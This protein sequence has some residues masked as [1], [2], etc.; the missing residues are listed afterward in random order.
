MYT[1]IPGNLFLVYPLLRGMSSFGVSFIDGKISL[2]YPF[3][4][5]GI[6]LD[7]LVIMLARY[8]L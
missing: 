8:D 4:D 2:Y 3:M 5:K 7:Y 6:F 1:T